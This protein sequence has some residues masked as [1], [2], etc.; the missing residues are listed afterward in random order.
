M[1]RPTPC[2]RQDRQKKAPKQRTT[3]PIPLLPRKRMAKSGWWRRA[4]IAPLVRAVNTV[5]TVKGRATVADAEA[6]ADA[7]AVVGVILS[8]VRLSQELLT[9]VARMREVRIVQVQIVRI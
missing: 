6:V 5:A 2:Q 7:V 8:I 4:R 3:K 9:R 1:C